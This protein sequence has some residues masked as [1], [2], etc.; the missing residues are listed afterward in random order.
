VVLRMP[1]SRFIFAGVHG[2][3]ERSGNKQDLGAHLEKAVMASDNLRGKSDFLPWT[4]Y[5]DRGQLYEQADYAVCTSGYHVET[6]FSMRT[7]LLDYLW[8]RLPIITT[9]GDMLSAKLGRAGAAVVVKNHGPALAEAMVALA[10]NASAS[11]KLAASADALASGSL[12]WRNT[13]RPL[14]TIGRKAGAMEHPPVHGT[15]ILKVTRYLLIR[16]RSSEVLAKGVQRLRAKLRKVHG[17]RR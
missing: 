12:A 5:V 11:H 13:V 4:S 2:A 3:N 15:A 9:S 16:R 7:R 10:T 14:L 17:D 6:Y 1:G 8:A